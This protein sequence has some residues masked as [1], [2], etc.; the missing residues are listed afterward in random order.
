MFGFNVDVPLGWGEGFYHAPPCHFVYVS[1][2]LAYRDQGRLLREIDPLDSRHPYG[3]SKAAAD[4]LL[5]A[6][7]AE[8]G[9]PLTILRPFSFTGLADESPRLF[10]SLLRAAAERQPFDLAPRDH[11]RDYTAAQDIAD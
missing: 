5:R 6:A 8:F 10:P 2:G 9:V 1:S 11:I 4:L 7:S 3:A